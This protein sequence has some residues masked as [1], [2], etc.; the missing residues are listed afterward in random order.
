MQKIHK[1]DDLAGVMVGMSL[2]SDGRKKQVKIVL[3]RMTYEFL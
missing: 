1:F 3:S 2:L